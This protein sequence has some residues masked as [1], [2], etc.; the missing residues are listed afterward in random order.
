MIW[1][2][3]DV[4]AMYAL[5]AHPDNNEYIVAGT[6]GNGLYESFDGGLTWHHA[7]LFGAHV[8]QIKFIPR[9]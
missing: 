7:G 8:Q 5:T 4:E 2:D 1:N 6:N 3:E 9:Y